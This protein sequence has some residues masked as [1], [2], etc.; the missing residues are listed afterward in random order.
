MSSTTFPINRVP[1]QLL[2]ANSPM[3]LC[4]KRSQIWLLTDKGLV[5]FPLHPPN[6]FWGLNSVLR[7]FLLYLWVILYLLVT[8][9]KLLKLNGLQKQDLLCVQ[10]YCFQETT[11]RFLT[12]LWTNFYRDQFP[13][14]GIIPIPLP[15]EIYYKLWQG[16]QI[17]IRWGDR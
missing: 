16:I 15:E 5:V 17:T 9:S 12:L 11:F 4:I 2:K 3:Q 14:L 1:S 7:L 8:T 6:P 10:R 13:D